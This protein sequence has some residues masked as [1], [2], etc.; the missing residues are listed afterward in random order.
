MTW[1]ELRA[2]GEVA[3]G[4]A[5]DFEAVRD[6]AACGVD[7]EAEFA[8]GVFC[9]EI[10]FAF[11]GIEALGGDDEMVDELLHRHHDIFLFRENSFG[12]GEVDVASGHGVEDLAANFDGLAHF[13]HADL[14][15]CVAVAFFGD[16]DVELVLFVAEVGAIFAEVAR[17]AR[18]AEVRASD[19]PVDG[20]FGR[21]HA[22]VGHAVDEDFVGIEE[23]GDFVDGGGAFIEEGA[24]G[25]LEAGWHVAELTADAGER[26]GETCAGEL[27]A[28]VVDFLAFGEG[29]EE[30]GH[31][32]D[33]H[34]A[35][36]N[37]EHVRGN[38]REFAAE[39]AEGLSARGKL[40][41]HEFFDGASVG[42]VV[43]EGCEVV[44]SVGVRDELV[45]VHVFGDF[46]VAA[47]KE[48]H[49]GDGGADDLA[50]EFQEEA[51]YAVSRWVGWAHVERHFFAHHVIGFSMIGFCR[52]GCAGEG[53]GG[54][55][56]GCLLCHGHVFA[57]I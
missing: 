13:L 20:V 14:V 45:V 15:A 1:K 43:G 3:E 6:A 46:L 24:H 36:A 38:S 47:V 22:D 11:G 28:E 54:F 49:V 25:L 33:V 42:D 52:L 17:N 39:D 2:D 31:G 12:V 16:G 9:S 18:G 10:D 50:V 53:I 4:G 56:F 26:S 34:G 5:A 41:A 57:A 23:L 44:Q 32:A 51:E 29:V 35:N 55:K 48:A 7:V 27:F 8:F 30:D 37:A 40:P 19:A 21:N